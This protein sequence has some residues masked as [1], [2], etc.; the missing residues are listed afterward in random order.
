MEQGENQNIA[1]HFP[2]VWSL[3]HRLGAV[4]VDRED[5]FQA[6]CVGLVQACRRYDASLGT[7][8]STYAAPLILGE[9]RRL[10]REGRPVRVPQGARQMVGEA[11]RLRQQ[12]ATSRVEDPPLHEV[13]AHLG[14]PPEELL[15]AEEALGVPRSLDGPA[16][17]ARE[18]NGNSLHEVLAAPALDED[19]GLILSEALSRLEPR[20]RLVIEGRYFHDLTQQELAERLGIS[21]PQVSR[22]EQQALGRLRTLL[23][24]PTELTSHRDDPPES[25]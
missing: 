8:F 4:G 17:G 12:L 20:H 18:E 24:S 11:R 22:L 3:V 5:L 21:Q 16:W 9:M 14:V 13:A 19:E 7:A 2:L 6:G 23:S 10:L 15:A 1:R 25:K